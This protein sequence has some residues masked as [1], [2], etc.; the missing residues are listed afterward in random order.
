VVGGRRSAPADDLLGALVLARDEGEA[1]SENELVALGMNLLVG[2]HESVGNQLGN[3]MVTLFD[4]PDLMAQLRTEPELLPGA[5]EELLRYI[6]L[7]TGAGATRIATE[8]VQVGDVV[9]KKGDAV[10]IV[11]ASTHRDESIFERPDELDISREAAQHNAFG[12]GPHFCPGAQ[13]ARMQLQVGVGTLLRRFPGLR[14]AEP[15]EF[16]TGGLLR[17]PRR[18]VVAW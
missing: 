14:L 16:R 5:I 3:A 2:G 8:D 7:P 1:L 4:H 12:F 6:P 15:V 17:G 13:L 10:L 11:T 18:L 9:V